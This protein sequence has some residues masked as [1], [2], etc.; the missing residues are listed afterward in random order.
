MRD[1]ELRARLEEITHGAD[2]V[3]LGTEWCDLS[4]GHVQCNHIMRQTG[5][6]I[7]CCSLKLGHEGGHRDSYIAAQPRQDQWVI[8]KNR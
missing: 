8:R 1:K 6:S 5:G 4:Q 7:L 3:R 2:G